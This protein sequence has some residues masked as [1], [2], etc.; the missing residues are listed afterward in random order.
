[1][2]FVKERIKK[3]FVMQQLYYIFEFDFF[4]STE[5]IYQHN[6]FFFVHN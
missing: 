3:S 6:F 5:R 4:I 1:M 2:I